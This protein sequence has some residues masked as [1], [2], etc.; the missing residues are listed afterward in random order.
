MYNKYTYIFSLKF[1]LFKLSKLGHIDMR[2]SYN[3]CI[4][5]YV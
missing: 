5:N 3:L 1:K 4:I 2:I